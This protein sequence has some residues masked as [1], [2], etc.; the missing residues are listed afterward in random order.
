MVCIFIFFINSTRRVQ[1]IPLLLEIT[2][3]FVKIC[4]KLLLSFVFHCNSGATRNVNESLGFFFTFLLMSTQ[5]KIS[6]F[7]EILFNNYSF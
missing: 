2:F 1:I 6:L 3:L 7:L 5:I 4:H